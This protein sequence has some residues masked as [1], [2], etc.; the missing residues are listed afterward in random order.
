MKELWLEKEP[1]AVYGGKINQLISLC[2]LGLSVPK[3]LILPADQV[4]DWLRAALPEYSKEGLKELIELGK[5]E[6]AERLQQYPLEPV[7]QRELVA[8]CQE[9]QAYIVRSSALLEDGQ[10][11][12]FAGQ[13]DSISNC[14][15]LSEI[16]QGIRSCLLS[17][18]NPEALAYW[19]RQGLAEQDFA[20]AVLIQEQIEPDLS[21][22]CFS[23]DV[24]T[25]KDQTMLLEYV[26]GSAES[27]VSG[28]V[29]P[30]QLTL[31]WYKPD[32]IQFEKVEMPLA[33]LQKLHEQ[34]LEIAAYFGRPMDIEWCAVQEQVY[35][36]Q[37]RPITTI[38]TKIDSGR[39]TTANFRDGGV[40]AQPCPNLMWSLYRHSWQ[41]ALSSFLLA[42]GLEPDGVIPPLM[43]LHYARPFWNLGV[44]KQGMEQIPGYI[45]RDFDDELGVN[46]DYQGQ[47][48]T[49]KLSPALLLNFL[50]VALKTQK[51]TK[52]FLHQAPEKLQELRQQFT[53]LNQEIREL[54]DQSQLQQVESLWQLVLSQ[55]YLDSEGTYFWQAYINTVQ[56]SMKKTS[57]LKWLTVDEF[58]QLIAKLGNV[59]HT[60][61][62][63]RMLEAADLVLADEKL[64]D[65]WLKLSVEELQ[66][67]AA[68]YPERAD[69]IKVQDFQRDFGYHSARE[70]DL[71]VASYEEDAHQVLTAVQQLVADS[72]YYQAA[73]ASLSP[74]SESEL[75][76]AHLSRAKQKKIEKISQDLRN[77]LWWREEFKDISTRYYHLIRQISLKLGQAYEKQGFLKDSQDIFYIKKES[78]T[79]FMEGQ[80]TADQLQE[81]VADNRHY[82]QAYRNF[83]PVGDLT[84]KEMSLEEV[85]HDSQ[86]L[87]TG[88]PA[89]SGQV[90]GRVRV[91][92]DLADIETIEP[93][94]ILVTRYTDTGWSYVFGILGG[95]VTEYGGVLCH[96]SIVARECG[97]PA[98]VCAKNATQLLETGMMVTLDGRRGEIRIHEEE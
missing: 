72:A 64:T 5:E 46:K 20:M 91:L 28:Q 61:P 59:S 97:I 37:A 94:E 33:V 34:V 48:F 41:E 95:L 83:E 29:N 11:M 31:P 40:A 79:A 21:G 35:L 19:Q 77:L 38:P 2:Q 66:E 16:E 55:A 36:L 56:L 1:S 23:L 65:D 43:R 3:G 47:G 25:N 24:A 58:F 18:F 90:T 15:T 62:L 84:D 89:S 22:V 71:R 50:R 45:E 26:K 78:L 96:A 13:Y 54:D 80:K 6:I 85:A 98:L 9:N 73:K 86:A 10:S 14:R 27:L 70:L 82:C 39:W 67:L 32:W 75:N 88:M 44:V 12:S 74:V 51:V 69:F 93:G 87:L 52:T 53:R 8:F 60:K 76:L 63:A 49:S 4:M 92:L 81:E 30:E 42:I 57:L 7:W 17:L 68:Q